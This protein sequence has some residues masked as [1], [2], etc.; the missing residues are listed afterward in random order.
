MTHLAQFQFEVIYRKGDANTNADVLFQHPLESNISPEQQKEME[1]DL[2]SRQHV[3]EAFGLQH[4]QRQPLMQHRQQHEKLESKSG[5]NAASA[6]LA[7]YHGSSWAG[8]QGLE[9]SFKR[10]ERDYHWS[11]M[12]RHLE[13]FIRT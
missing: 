8:H 12:R 2:G 4:K 10:L 9:K 11:G 1:M 5:H 6:I 3:I 13:E 7:E